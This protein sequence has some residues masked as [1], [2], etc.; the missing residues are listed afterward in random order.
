MTSIFSKRGN[1]DKSDI[2]KSAG[3]QEG[4]ELERER[5]ITRLPQNSTESK[6]LGA[7]RHCGA[8]CG[9]FGGNQ[10]KPHRQ[11]VPRFQSVSATSIVKRRYICFWRELADFGHLLTLVVGEF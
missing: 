11:L 7:T 9:L 6:K 4:S 2:R 5:V 1:V 8:H 3:K 10:S